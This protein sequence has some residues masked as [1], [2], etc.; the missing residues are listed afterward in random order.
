MGY[1]YCM[2]D[3]ADSLYASNQITSSQRTKLTTCAR[4]E[5]DTWR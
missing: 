5:A 2:R 1:F 3:Y 4:R